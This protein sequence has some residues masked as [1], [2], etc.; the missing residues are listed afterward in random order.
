MS[1]A[2]TAPDTDLPQAATIPATTPAMTQGTSPPS[3]PAASVEG[4]VHLEGDRVSDGAADIP[5]GTTPAEGAAWERVVGEHALDEHA[6]T[7]PPTEHVDGVPG[8]ARLAVPEP[9]PAEPALALAF[10]DARTPRR[11][12]ARPVA[13]ETLRT[14][15]DLVR[16]GPTSANCSP[17]RFVFL[18][19]RQARERLVPALSTGNVELVLD[20]AVT[21]IVAHD[22]LFFEQ[23][24][25]LWPA[26][27]LRSWFAADAALADETA[28]RNGTLQGG[29]LIIAA[30]LLGLDAAPMSGFDN[31][32]VDDLFLSGQG[33]RSNFLV[34]LG[35]AAEAPDRPRAPR[36]AFDEACLLL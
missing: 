18:R 19:S 1:G 3:G 27:E 20:A 11:W 33:W 16:L 32:R 22:P 4:A 12:S 29:Y 15:Y 31:S 8:G 24:P 26:A 5:A 35:H 9:D 13:D 25:R 28:L 17:A 30:R 34:S 23:M 21:V 7:E 10:R 14:L 36:L 6:G 2:A